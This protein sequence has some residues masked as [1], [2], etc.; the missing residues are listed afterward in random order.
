MTGVS[1][2][3][4]KVERPS[5]RRLPHVA[6]A[7]GIPLSC[8]GGRRES[9]F[10]ILDDSWSLLLTCQWDFLLTKR[11]WINCDATSLHYG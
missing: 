2:S 10:G 3:P 4:Y 11:G 7:G 5:V 1:W 6:A 8:A 9:E